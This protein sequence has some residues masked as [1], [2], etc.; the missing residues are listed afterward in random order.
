[1][2]YSETHAWLLKMPL[3]LLALTC[4]TIATLLT[5]YAWRH[6]AAVARPGALDDKYFIVDGDLSLA[7]VAAIVGTIGVVALVIWILR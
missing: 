3:P 1:M 5:F 4:F 7:I 2:K 6:S